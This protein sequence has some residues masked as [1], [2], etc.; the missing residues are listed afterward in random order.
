MTSSRTST[1]T[2]RSSFIRDTNFI[3]FINDCYEQKGQVI[4][5]IET[6]EPFLK[7]ALV[8]GDFCFYIGPYESD[9]G[10]YRKQRQ[11]FYFPFSK[12]YRE[13]SLELFFTTRLFSIY[14]TKAGIEMHIAFT[15][16]YF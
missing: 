2:D 4:F 11:K 6:I 3:V 7:F 10:K 15:K 12:I 8:C 14:F 5:N 9:F 13:A 1:S 16:I